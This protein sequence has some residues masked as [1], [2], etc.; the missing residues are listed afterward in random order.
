[1]VKPL[2][3]VIIPCY[4]QARYLPE[5]ID[6]AL[7][8]TH[9]PI[10]VV[11]V[12]DGSPDDTREVCR[13]YAGRIVYVEQ[14]NQGRSAA[15]NAGVAASAGQWLQFLDADD[16]LAPRKIEW[17]LQ[18]LQQQQA[19]IG[20][21]CTVYFREGPF[22]QPNTCQYVG[23]I[24]DMTAGLASLWLGTPLP[25]HCVLMRRDVFDANGGFPRG[26]EIDEDRSFFLTI[27]LTGENFHF[28][29]VIGAY[30]R[31]HSA[32]TNYSNHI[33]IIMSNFRFLQSVWTLAMEG[34]L[35]RQVLRPVIQRSCFILAH[36][37]VKSGAC[38]SD[39]KPV[40]DFSSEFGG[41]GPRCERL[42]RVLPSWMV[43]RLWAW[44]QKWL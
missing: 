43:N 1:M 37:I 41:P 20:Y 6:S 17:Q 10:Q 40:L 12:N 8:Q 28:T 44:R 38:W 22:T 35:D 15:R 31:Q 2:V 18:D 36:A 25:I 11:V 24:T 26:V 42:R 13:R 5:A 39:L 3:S 23:Q 4:R 7:G 9:Q 19:R 21:C 33:A 32:S 29:P 34:K 27:A 14:P 16:L 30:Y